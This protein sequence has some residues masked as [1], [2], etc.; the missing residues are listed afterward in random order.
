M[1]PTVP[2]WPARRS[3]V[4]PTTQHAPPAL[5]EGWELVPFDGMRPAEAPLPPA[6]LELTAYSVRGEP[7]HYDEAVQGPFAPIHV[8]DPWGPPWSTTWFHVRGRV[9]DSYAGQGVV[10]VFDLGFDGPTG[11]TCE[12]LAWKHGQPWRGVDPN[13]PC[14]PIHGPDTTFSLKTPANPRATEAGAEPSLSMLALR[15]SPEPSFVLRQAQLPL[16]ESAA[17][18]STHLL[19]YLLAPIATAALAPSH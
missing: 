16:H 12:A 18:V 6:P 19:R 10:A 8:G 15:Q 14:L 2:E 17:A 4:I 5:A 1:R 7:I 11:F 3:V 9:P 13:H